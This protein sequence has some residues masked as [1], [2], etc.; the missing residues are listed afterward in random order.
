MRLILFIALLVCVYSPSFCQLPALVDDSVL[1]QLSL[2]DFGNKNIETTVSFESLA[3]HKKFITKT[4]K[5]GKAVIKIAA[6]AS[7]NVTIPVSSDT[8]EY[9]VPEFAASPA[10]LNLKYHVGERVAITDVPPAVAEQKLRTLTAIRVF[11][12]NGI[13]SLSIKKKG[14]AEETYSIRNDTVYFFADQ[15][16][17]YT[18]SIRNV[19]ITN[20]TIHT[21]THN[22]IA[23]ALF[24]SDSTKA[25]LIELSTSVSLLNVVYKNL[26]DRP[27]KNETVTVRGRR[28]S[29]VYRSTTGANGCAAFLLP[30]NDVYSIS[31]PCFEEADSIVVKEGKTKKSIV[32]N[33]IFFSYP[34]C[35]EFAEM[36]REDS[37]RIV[38]RDSLYKRFEKAKELTQANLR[39]FLA[40]EAEKAVKELKTDTAYFEKNNNTVCAVMQRNKWK[41]KMIV[42][43]VTGSMYPYMQQVALW[44]LLESMDKRTSG[45]V[46]FNDGN[47]MPDSKKITGK[48]GGIYYCLQQQLDSMITVMY[49][50]VNSGSGGDAP[51]N[52]MEALLAATSA[53]QPNAELILVA[54][55]YSTVRDI[56]LLEKLDIPVR[57]ILCGGSGYYIN[58]DY[59]LIAYK[60]G[61]SIHTI[62]NDIRDL[63]ATRD[64]DVLYINGYYYKFS[65]GKF[66]PFNKKI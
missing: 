23:Y 15:Q 29:K 7:Y 13:S 25:E 10:L 38:R 26:Y 21:G 46:F 16:S 32:T 12:G 62:E 47:N 5:E 36:K 51:E 22:E 11:N 39:V 28:L 53:M 40:A 6:A 56:S 58:S 20:R 64:G 54:D 2:T 43:D 55:N 17:D 52:D 33:T 14:S 42:T 35:R 45:Y 9:E 4:N 49:R 44:H 57:I 60:T 63:S 66:F 48:T 3:T 41:Q 1:I 18:V 37:M 19:S 30:Q 50:A 65:G 31:L 34:S 61:G 27:V 24:F 59:L 8:Y